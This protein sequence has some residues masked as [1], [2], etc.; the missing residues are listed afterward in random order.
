M[1]KLCDNFWSLH[2][3]CKR[4]YYIIL[5]CAKLAPGTLS[6]NHF[7]IASDQV[8]RSSTLYDV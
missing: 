6:I 1:T 4:D 3:E 7:G 2:A 8:V 5:W